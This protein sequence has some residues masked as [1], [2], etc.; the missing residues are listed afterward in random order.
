MKKFKTLALAAAVS[1]GLLGAAGVMAATQG[2][3]EETSNGDFTIFLNKGISVAVWGFKDLYFISNST[4]IPSGSETV[5]LCVTNS[6]A[7]DS[8]VRF[9][10]EST[11]DNFTLKNDSVVGG[12]YTVTIE[13]KGSS[14][15]KALWGDGGL[16]TGLFSEE[17]FEAGI[18]EPLA[19]A[20]LCNTTSDN[21]TVNMKIDVTPDTNAVAGVYSDIVTVTVTPI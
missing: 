18:A 19:G 1:A 4:A 20:T 11:S 9:M 15:T 6:G 21:H 10:V 12:S 8:Q 3:L 13:D 14:S 7:P 5:A 16:T 17:A 2:T